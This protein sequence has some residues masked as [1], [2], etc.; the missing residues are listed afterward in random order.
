[1][2]ESQCGELFTPAI[3]EYVSTDREPTSSQSEQGCEDHTFGRVNAAGH[4]QSGDHCDWSDQFSAKHRAFP[5]DR[6]A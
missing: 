5:A 1:V 3:E 2:A 6:F 4:R